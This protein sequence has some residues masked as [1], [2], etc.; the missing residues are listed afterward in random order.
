MLTLYSLFLVM[1]RFIQNLMLWVKGIYSLDYI[2]AYTFYRYL[3]KIFR[4]I[5]LPNNIKIYVNDE[6]TLSINVPDMYERKEYFLY[7]EFVPRRGWTVMD[8]GAYVGIFSLHASKAVGDEGLV[9]SFEPNPLAYYWLMNNIRLNKADNVVA[10]PLA[11]G[12][13]SGKMQLY[14][15]KEN[16][17]A[18]SLIAEHV[19]QNPAGKYTVVDKFYVPVT[20]LDRFLEE[21][22]HYMNKPIRNLDL[23]KMDVE[24]YEL[25]VLK[26]AEKT[27]KEGLIMRLIIEVH[28]DQVSTETV[29]QHLKK[30]GF[31]IVEIKHFGKVK[32]II[33]ANL[34][35]P[36]EFVESG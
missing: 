21:N 34:K 25:K 9:L 33:Y 19:L 22:K 14:V 30:Y 24:G 15:A 28:V 26:G 12:D 32:D 5:V 3:P 35:E 7:E 29:I 6:A 10:F 18:S 36:K 13:A 11:L 8:I 16:I 27:L 4:S 20:T 2:L 31:H 1:K 17:G 23:V